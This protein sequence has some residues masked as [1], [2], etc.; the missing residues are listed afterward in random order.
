M[1]KAIIRK[2]E[3]SH[4]SN[5]R[6][7]G[8]SIVYIESPFDKVAD[9]WFTA[10][11]VMNLSFKCKTWNK[12]SRMATKAA[13]SSLKELFP[14]ALK[15]TFSAKA[16]CRCGCSPGYIMKHQPNQYGRTFWVD[17]EASESEIESFAISIN[18]ARLTHEFEEEIKAN[19]KE[20]PSLQTV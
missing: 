6:N 17:I 1:M 19:S 5:R 14:E 15:I 7:A 16:G 9:R 12:I 13:L 10:N 11:R 18:C 3:G 20:E 4:H 2:S 8:R